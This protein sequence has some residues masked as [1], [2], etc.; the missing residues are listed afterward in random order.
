MYAIRSYYGDLVGS[1]RSVTGSVF[2][3]LAAHTAL[4][5]NLMNL[6]YVFLGGLTPELTEE[7]AALIRS[8][9]KV[10][11]PYTIAQRFV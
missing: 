3:E 9:I 11:W 6:D 10:K 4:L 2:S 7:L 5:A 1:D 8:E